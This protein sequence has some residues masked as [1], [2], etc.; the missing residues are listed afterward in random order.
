MDIQKHGSQRVLRIKNFIFLLIYSVT[1]FFDR[2]NE[3]Q[4]SLHSC[5]WY[6]AI[7]MVSEIA[8]VTGFEKNDK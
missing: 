2:V 7:N 1:I 6:R 4:P 5:Y 8:E 3:E